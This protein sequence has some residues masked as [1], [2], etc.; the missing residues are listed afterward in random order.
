MWWMSLCSAWARGSCH[1]SW[2]HWQAL[3]GDRSFC[4][5]DG[6][7]SIRQVFLLGSSPHCPKHRQSS[8]SSSGHL[9]QQRVLQPHVFTQNDPEACSAGVLARDDETDSA[10]FRRS[11]TSWMYSLSLLISSGLSASC[12]PY[13]T[14]CVASS[15]HLCKGLGPSPTSPEHC[16]SEELQQAGCMGRFAVLGLQWE[17][18]PLP[19]P[20]ALL[21]IQHS[22]CMQKN[23]IDNLKRQHQWLESEQ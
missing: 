6:A 19:V 7:E 17:P 15:Q 18:F 20:S 3:P 16:S 11:V 2:W 12:K 8:G 9:S 5:M 4:C 13:L 10:W 21:L 23:Y 22:T 1:C 14:S